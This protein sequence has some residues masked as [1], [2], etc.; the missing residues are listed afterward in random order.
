LV[1][2]VYAIGFYLLRAGNPKLPDVPPG[3]VS[4]GGDEVPSALMAQ[5][6]LY[7]QRLTLHEA[8][9]EIVRQVPGLVWGLVEDADRTDGQPTCRL[10]WFTAGGTSFGSYD[11]L[12]MRSK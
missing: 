10:T 2:P 3:I 5:V 11:F 7:Y 6:S 8:L 9:D 12:R 4:G 1:A